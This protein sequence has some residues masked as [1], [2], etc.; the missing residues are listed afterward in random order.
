MTAYTKMQELNLREA[1]L[2]DR[3]VMHVR[4]WLEGCYENTPWIGAAEELHKELRSTPSGLRGATHVVSANGVFTTR[5]LNACERKLNAVDVSYT[6][7]GNT[8]NKAY[9]LQFVGE[10]SGI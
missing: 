6:D 9:R 10:P 5:W 7:V 4:N 2:S 1:A 3:L 8:K